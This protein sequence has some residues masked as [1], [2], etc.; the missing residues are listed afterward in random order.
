MKHA[1]VYVNRGRW[2]VDCPNEECCW[3]YAALT[4]D[5]RPRYQYACRGDSKGRGCGTMFALVWPALDEAEAITEVLAARSL[6]ATRNWYP[7]E[8]VEHLMKENADHLVGRDLAW[9]AEQGI[10]VVC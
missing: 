6:R 10:G 1:L 7:N 8:T 2:L 9:L 4:A 5:G 3:A